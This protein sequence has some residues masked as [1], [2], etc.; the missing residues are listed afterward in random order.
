MANFKENNFDEVFKNKFMNFEETPPDFIYNNLKASIS[1]NSSN[2]TK[3]INFNKN[4]LIISSAIIIAII[5]ITIYYNLN[6]NNFKTTVSSGNIVKNANNISIQSNNQ[7]NSVNNNSIST[8]NTTNSNNNVIKEYNISKS[9]NTQNSYNQFDTTICGLICSLNQIIPQANTGKWSTESTNLTLVSNKFKNAYDDPE[10]LIKSDKYGK[11]KLYW[12]ST[13]NKQV[14][15]TINFIEQP[16]S[17]KSSDINVCGNEYQ[18][19]LS[20]SSNNGLWNFITGV[21][22]ENNKLINTKVYYKNTGKVQFIWTETNAQCISKDTVNVIFGNS[23]AMDISFKI[24]PATCRNNNGSI[25]ASISANDDLSYYWY[26]VENTNSNILDNLYSGEYHL[27]VRNKNNCEAVFDIFVPD[28][29]NVVADFVHSELEQTVSVPIYFT[30]KSKTDGKNTEGTVYEWNFGDNLRSSETNPEHIYTREGE[31]SVSLIAKSSYGCS[32]TITISDINIS[33]AN[34]EAP[35]IFSPNG[36]GINDIFKP[37]VRS[38]KSFIC[39]IFNKEGQQI[40][41][42]DDV[43]A[44]WDGKIKND[45][46][47]EGNYYYVVS[48]IDNNN[49]KYILKGSFILIRK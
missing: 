14:E 9:D 15:I 8:V 41:E 10:A 7:G 27:K 5:S 35:N 4:L 13:D 6:N 17:I 38:S 20:K 26:P 29:G 49:K 30:N 39:T 37:K 19:N 32:D 21:K 25:T 18:F 43:N 2:I 48:G 36:D 40:Y 16:K 1:N 28:S 47:A 24:V 42:W 34:P 31:Y 33:T 3:K 23:S 12:N 44:G 46:A 45:L 11:Y 22:Y